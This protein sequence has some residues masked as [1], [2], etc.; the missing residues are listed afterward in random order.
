M[1]DERNG[2]RKLLK[3][4]DDKPEGPTNTADYEL[5]ISALVAFTTS[6]DL[7]VFFLARYFVFRIYS[8]AII[9]LFFF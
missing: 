8:N 6:I 9:Y 4:K 7:R 3:T 1:R 2:T 5:W